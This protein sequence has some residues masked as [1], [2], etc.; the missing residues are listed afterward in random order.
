MA[1]NREYV[2][3]ADII[4][5]QASGTVRLDVVDVEEKDL[6]FRDK[7]T[8][9]SEGRYARLMDGDEILMAETPLMKKTREDFVSRA[10]GDILIGGLGIGLV[11]LPIQGSPDV[12]SITVV[13]NNSDVIKC[14]APQ[15]PFNEKVTIVHDD[16]F[17]YEPQKKKRYDCI[18]FDIWNSFDRS[19]YWNEMVPLKNRYVWEMRCLKMKLFR[20]N[21]VSCWCEEYARDN[22]RLI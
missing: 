5:P 4:T 20:N 10:Y 21:I 8:G 16:I 17:A 2:K 1:E 7:L 9:L 12:K 11:I 6:S 18:Y 3:I 13:E 22:M 19:T 15:L 14:V